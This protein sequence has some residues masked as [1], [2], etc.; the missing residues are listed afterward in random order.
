MVIPGSPTGSRLTHPPIAVF[1]GLLDGVYDPPMK[2]REHRVGDL[3]TKPYPG[4]PSEG[5]SEDDHGHT[6]VVDQR[7]GRL[8]RY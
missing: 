8:L 7:V 3:L 6:R 1:T 2:E 5:T 4:L